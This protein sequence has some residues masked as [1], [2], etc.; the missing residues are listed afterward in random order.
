MGDLSVTSDGRELVVFGA[1]AGVV[2][3]WRLDGS[4]PVTKMVAAGHYAADGFDATGRSLVV[5]RRPPTATSGDDVSEYALWDPGSDRVR[6]ALPPISGAGWIGPDLLFGMSPASQRGCVPRR[7]VRALAPAVPG[8]R[9]RCER[10][11]PG[12]DGGRYYALL[13]DGTVWTLDTATRRRIAPTFRVGGDALLGLGHARRK[14]RRDH[15]VPTLR[16]HGDHSPRRHDRQAPG[17]SA[18]RPVPDV[19]EPRRQAG[20]R[21][22]AGEIT[23]YDLDTLRP[24]ASF[25]GARGEVNTLQFSADSSTLLATS[26]DQTASIYDVATRTRIGDPIAADAPYVYP[27]FLSPDGTAV[28]V[29]VRD[30]IALWDIDPEHLAAAACNLADRNLTAA[31]WEA[32]LGEIGTYR[33]SCR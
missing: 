21:Q 25:P 19:G 3:R 12:A 11:L 33:K 24:I 8:C 31:E 4:G 9:T 16:K 17:R 1:Q 20:R 14:A 13:S 10:L 22:H 29:T 7:R 23:E 6:T 18:A 26:L 2:S 15:H 32:Y 30:G 5:A 27:A 28:A